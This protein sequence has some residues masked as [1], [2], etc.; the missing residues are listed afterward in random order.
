MYDFNV[1]I[2]D[3]LVQKATTAVAV[4]T[5]LTHLHEHISRGFPV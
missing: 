2:E 5:A 1:T 4:G 3:F